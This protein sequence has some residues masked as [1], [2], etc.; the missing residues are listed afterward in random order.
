MV[1]DELNNAMRN[2]QFGDSSGF[3]RLKVAM[4]RWSK[5][6][7]VAGL[8]W[9]EYQDAVVEVGPAYEE[10]TDALEAMSKAAPVQWEFYLSNRD[11]PDEFLVLFAEEVPA[12]TNAFVESC[13]KLRAVVLKKNETKKA[14]EEAAN[15]ELKMASKLFRSAERDI[16]SRW[17]YVKQILAG[18][19]RRRITP[20]DR[21]SLSLIPPRWIAERFPFIWMDM[22]EKLLMNFEDHLSPLYK[23][24]LRQQEDGRD[25]LDSPSTD[26]ERL[27]AQT[28]PPSGRKKKK[29]TLLNE[30]GFKCWGC[31]FEAPDEDERYLHL[32]HISPKS[33]GGSDDIGNLALL[34]QPCNDK[35]SNTM[36]L[37]GLRQANKSKGLMKT[38]ELIDLVEARNLIRDKFR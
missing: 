29:K 12:Q 28:K 4:N 23:S 31:G 5:V 38:D 32:D 36:S 6:E 2:L 8:E 7:E 26:E 17:I 24:A 1:T 33:E 30:F 15:S 22:V 20:E 34:C 10:Y 16:D 18:H 19:G 3:A 25:D 21:R 37:E 13:S 27:P 11:S 14:F 9:K 35:K